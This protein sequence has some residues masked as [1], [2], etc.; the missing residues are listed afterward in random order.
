MGAAA[1]FTLARHHS[2]DWRT[3]PRPRYGLPP[4]PS[5]L[6]TIR[7]TGGHPQGPGMG[8]PPP[9][10]SL[11]TFRLTGERLRPQYGAAAPFT[12]A[13]HYSTDWGTPQTPVWGCR[14]LHPR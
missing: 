7:V 1:P 5:S 3:P 6:D 14:P 10:P 13:R 8:L 11:G 4:P 2:T 12:L 9:S